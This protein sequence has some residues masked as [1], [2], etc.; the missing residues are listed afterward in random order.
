MLCSFVR[1]RI[2][3]LDLVGSLTGI[4]RLVVYGGWWYYYTVITYICE[5]SRSCRSLRSALSLVL[6]DRTHMEANGITVMLM[7][8]SVRS[9][10]HAPQSGQ[11]SRWCCRLVRVRMLMVSLHCS[12]VVCEMSHSTTL[13]R[14]VLSPILSSWSCLDADGITTLFF[15]RRLSWIRIF[16]LHPSL[17]YAIPHPS[18]NIH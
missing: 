5:I 8:S 3:A 13:L 16:P 11:F 7:C 2:Y 4:A 12:R 9:S 10:L 18:R 1:C 17:F 15:S 14:A 6:H